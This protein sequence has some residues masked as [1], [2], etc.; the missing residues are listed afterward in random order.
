MFP[1]WEL[2]AVSCVVAA[3]DKARRVSFDARV[4]F[5]SD[6]RRVERQGLTAGSSTV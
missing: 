1:S 5:R 4:H 2:G 6:V 3:N